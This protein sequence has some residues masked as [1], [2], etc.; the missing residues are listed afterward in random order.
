MVIEASGELRGEVYNIASGVGS[1]IRCVLDLL[2][3]RLQ[4]QPE[5]YWSGFVRPGEPSR[6]IADISRIQ[7]LGWQPKVSL[8]VGLDRTV[9]WFKCTTLSCPDGGVAPD[10]KAFNL[11]ASIH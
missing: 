9:E 3:S 10:D 5:L 6:W 1:S 8:E 7:A 11:S 4:V 2:S